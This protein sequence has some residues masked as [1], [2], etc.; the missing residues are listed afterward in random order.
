VLIVITQ[1]PGKPPNTSRWACYKVRN[2]FN[3][4]PQNPIKPTGLGFKNGYFSKE[5]R[6]LKTSAD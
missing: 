5:S 1:N 6:R 3:S 2:G 4:S